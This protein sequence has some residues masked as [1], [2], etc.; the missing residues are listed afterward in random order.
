MPE[1]NW[2]DRERNRDEHFPAHVQD[3]ND[4]R[5]KNSECDDA[6][7][8][9]DIFGVCDLI[10]SG[11]MG[12][13]SEWSII[14]QVHGL[15]GNLDLVPV[16]WQPFLPPAIVQW[17]RLTRMV[18]S[19]STFEFRKRRQ[20]PSVLLGTAKWQAA[21]SGLPSLSLDDL[22]DPVRARVHQDSASIND[23]VTIA[24]S[25]IFRGHVVIGNAISRKVG[26]DSH[27]AVV[28]VR[29]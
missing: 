10:E 14:H 3:R 4:H 1:R 9:G 20:S 21:D 16:C 5:R 23:R 2:V 18:H 19:Q 26:A 13:I 15:M 11:I 24:G 27:I 12:S 8:R 28:V 6:D 17:P 7:Q 25:T 29:R 22:N